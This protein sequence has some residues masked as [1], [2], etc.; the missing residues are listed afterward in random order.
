MALINCKSCG[1][2]VD[3]TAK[4]CPNC[5]YDYEGY[6]KNKGNLINMVFTLVIVAILFFILKFFPD[7]IPSLFKSK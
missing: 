2:Q 1:R 7:L 6:R 4:N 3:T 5:G